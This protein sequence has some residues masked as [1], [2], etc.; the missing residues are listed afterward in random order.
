MLLWEPAC[1]FDCITRD[2]HDYR[3]PI[4]KL[5][6]LQLSRTKEHHTV[7][8]AGKLRWTPRGTRSDSKPASPKI[9]LLVAGNELITSHI[10][11][12][13]VR[14]SNWV[15]FRCTLKLVGLEDS[16]S[17]GNTC[18]TCVQKLRHKEKQRDLTLLSI[19]FYQYVSLIMLT[20]AQLQSENK[21]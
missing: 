10:S 13:L 17:V 5:I 3:V 15:S 6:K 18:R 4:T 19:C 2:R 8:C 21:M 16:H 7:H 20:M 14:A 11:L 12:M 9:S 1:R